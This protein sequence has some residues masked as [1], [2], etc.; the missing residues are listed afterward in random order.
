MNLRYAVLFFFAVAV[1]AVTGAVHAQ[2]QYAATFHVTVAEKTPEHPYYNL[3]YHQG[4][5]VNGLQ[6][7]TI[8]LV[9][10]SLYLF[11]TDDVPNDLVFDFYTV[12]IGG[13]IGFYR[14]HVEKHE[15]SKALWTIKADEDDPD[16]LYYASTEQP[17]MGGTILI[18]DSITSSVE[19]RR[20]PASVG[21]LAG[22]HIYPNPFAGTAEIRFALDARA[23]VRVEIADV[24]GQ[25][26]LVRE[27]KDMEGGPASVLLEAAGLAPGVYFYRIEAIQERKRSV[28]TGT[29][30]I[31]R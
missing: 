16:T 2:A 15:V 3:G 27:L 23:D 14:H 6:S 8:T 1:V 11:N 25:V 30:Q 7:P 13:G 21:V 26:V 12:P 28:A 31:L 5:V 17:W 20:A 22:A 29:M 18:V 10:D 4:Y 24:L 19:E 9:R